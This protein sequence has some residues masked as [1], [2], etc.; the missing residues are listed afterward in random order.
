[1]SA[2]V[3]LNG[4]SKVYR[5]AQGAAAEPRTIKEA[6]V[7]PLRR[8]FGAARAAEPA[9]FRAL[10]DVSF[11]IDEGQAFGLIGRNGAGKSTLLK[12][13]S[14]ITAPSGGELRVHGRVGSLLEVGA[15]F[16]PELSGRENVFL[17]GALNG[18]LPA[19][20]RR[21]FD[22]IVAF[23]EIEAFLDMP[24]KHYSSGMYMKL[25]F[26]VAAHMDPDILLVDEALAVGD[27]PFQ[28]KCLARMRQLV[29]NSRTVVLV[30]HNPHSISTFCQSAAWLDQ[31]RLVRAGESGEVLAAY[32]DSIK[33][34][35]M[36]HRWTG[37]EG[38]EVLRLRSTYVRFADG[39]SPRTDRAI[40]IGFRAELRQP[41]RNLVA[42]VELAS[43]Q[44][45]LLAYSAHDDALPPPAEVHPPGEFAWELTVPPNT[46]AAGVYSVNFDFGVH[47]QRRIIDRAG[48]LM[49]ELENP[50]G[51]GRRFPA[52]KWNGIL[53]PAW[54]WRPAGPDPAADD[55]SQTA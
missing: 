20:I 27:I 15:G 16:H 55:A 12:I 8:A 50:A 43:E 34:H 40:R 52:E 33:S 7:R 1:M 23:S 24:V 10:D 51:L 6:I 25:A 30:S 49:F 53:R 13:I 3:S 11:D 18:M 36:T 14:K 9:E 48:G 5:S 35:R 2:A 38:D 31:G 46:L 47:N 45:A 29:A 26:S 21:R 41:V 22:E 37:D 32:L 39:G 44:G 54:A 28:R 4:V 19:W 42:A 17:A